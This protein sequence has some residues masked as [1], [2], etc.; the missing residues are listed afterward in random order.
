MHKIGALIL[1]KWCTTIFFRAKAEW[2]ICSL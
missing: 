2:W 1:I